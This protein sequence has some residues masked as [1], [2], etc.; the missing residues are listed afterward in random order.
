L[1]TRTF[2]SVSATAPAGT[3]SEPYPSC[4]DLGPDADSYSTAVIV[5]PDAPVRTSP[6][7]S[8]PV[9]AT[10]SY[11]TAELV[12]LVDGWGQIELP[13]GAPGFIAESDFQIP[14][15][16]RAYFSRPEGGSWTMTMFLAGD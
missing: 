11:E 9:V 16:W 8:A 4:I 14:A 13:D 7:S 6:D 15:G 10:L 5:S 2:G 12:S 3:S 1:Q